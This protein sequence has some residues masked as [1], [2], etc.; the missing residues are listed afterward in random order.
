MKIRYSYKSNSGFIVLSMMLLMLNTQQTHATSLKHWLNNTVDNHPSVLSAESVI[1]EA[2]FNKEAAAK[3]V[4]NPELEIDTESIEDVNTTTVGI[5]QTIDWGDSRGANMAVAKSNHAIATYAFELTQRQVA[6]RALAA[7]ANLYT[8]ESLKALAEQRN[9]LMQRIQK[10]AKRRFSYGDL[11]SVDVDLAKLSYAQAR[12]NLSSSGSDLIRAKQHVIALTGR[13]IGVLPIMPLDF[14]DPQENKQNVEKT[15]QQLPSM[16]QALMAIK[17]AQANIKLQASQNAV[18]PTIALRAGREESD[19]ILGLTLSI[20]L[21]V[22]NDFKAEVNAA[23][24]VMIQR[25]REAVAVHRELYSQFEITTVSYGLSREAWMFWQKTGAGIL[26]GQITLLERLWKAGEL[27]TSDYLLQL[28]QALETKESAIEQRGRLWE[29]WS[30]WLLATGKIE[31]WLQ[32]T[33][34]DKE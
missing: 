19:H 25:E 8:S 18:N 26:S 29:D 11:S 22:R 31:Q 30:A 9:E 21:Q 23:N 15:I 14:P 24:E 4:Y 1:S 27:N 5:S 16:L 20:P 6:Q 2:S 34:G 3:A 33:A 17:S 13:N 12:F 32:Q 7:L 10:I 28:K